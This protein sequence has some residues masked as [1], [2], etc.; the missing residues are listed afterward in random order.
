MTRTAIRPGR[1]YRNA[2]GHRRLVLGDPDVQGGHQHDRDTL[3]YRVVQGPREGQEFV[4][5]RRA[6]ARWAVARVR[7]AKKAA[8]GAG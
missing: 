8:V 5:T 2:E 7:V 1:T 6:L 4:C 3:T